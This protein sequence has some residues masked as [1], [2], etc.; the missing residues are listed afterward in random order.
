MDDKN[1]NNKKEEKQV[2][3]EGEKRN[4]M[5]KKM[6]VGPGN[7]WNNILSTVLLLIALTLVYSY[8]TDTTT[9]PEELS[10]S[11]VAEQIKAGEVAQI[12][13]KGDTLEV[14]YTDETRNSGEAKK[15]ND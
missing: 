12:I 11:Q 9:K 1:R 2:K 14:A 6:P 4:Y 3:K 13:I 5:P 7:F 8:I 15:D 10:V